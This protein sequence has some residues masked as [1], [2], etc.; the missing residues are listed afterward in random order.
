MRFPLSDDVGV[1]FDDAWVKLI[2][3]CVS[4]IKYMVVHDRYK[5]GPIIPE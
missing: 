4:T 5:L 3:L 1:G 2:M